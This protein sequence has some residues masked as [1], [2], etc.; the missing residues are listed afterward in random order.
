MITNLTEYIVATSPWTI[1]CRNLT[2]IWIQISYFSLYVLVQNNNFSSWTVNYFMY[3]NYL[4]LLGTSVKCLG[5]FKHWF[6]LNNWWLMYLFKFNSILCKMTY[7]FSAVLRSRFNLM[8]CYF[9]FV[10]AH[11]PVLIMQIV[12]FPVQFSRNLLSR[13]HCS[14][15]IQKF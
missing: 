15:V 12:K 5:K 9:C 4:L 14:Y 3:V 7:S 10:P 8:F 11:F 6:V 1:F 13:I 2:I